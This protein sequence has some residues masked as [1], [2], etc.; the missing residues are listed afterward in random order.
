VTGDG[1]IKLRINQRPNHGEGRQIGFVRDADMLETLAHTP[2]VGRRLPIELFVGEFSD[3][4]PGGQVV[5]VQVRSKADG[6][7]ARAP[8]LWCGH[9]AEHS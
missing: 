9:N 3:E 1:S 8:F 4:L 6:P 5:G 7:S 2:R